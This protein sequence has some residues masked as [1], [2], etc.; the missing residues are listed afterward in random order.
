VN[1]QARTRLDTLIGILPQIIIYLDPL[2]QVIRH[3]R[4]LGELLAAGVEDVSGEK[5]LDHLHPWSE[6][7]ARELQR[8][9]SLPLADG[10]ELRVE[11]AISLK[12]SWSSRGIFRAELQYAGEEGEYLLMLE[13]V[14]SL[15]Q[16]EEEYRRVQ[17]IQSLLPLIRGFGADF[18]DRLTVIFGNLDFALE[19]L[20]LRGER[21]EDRIGEIRDSLSSVI[22][23]LERSNGRLDHILWMTDGGRKTMGE[24]SLA[25][26]VKEVGE[27]A[28]LGSNKTLEVIVANELPPYRGDYEKILQM[29]QNLLVNAVQAGPEAYQISISLELVNRKG[30][31][32]VLISI[33]DH[34]EGMAVDVLARA[35]QPF[36]T[37]RENADG[38]GLF[39]AKNIALEHNG[40]IELE[41]TPGKGSKVHIYLPLNSGESLTGGE[42]R[43]PEGLRVLILDDNPDVRD[44]WERLLY[45]LGIHGSFV[46]SGAK[47]FE[48]FEKAQDSD[49][50]FHMAILED[51][52]SDSPDVFSLVERLSRIRPGLPAVYTTSKAMKLTVDELRDRGFS[53]CLRKPF[54]LVDLQNALI[55]ALYRDQDNS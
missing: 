21:T 3:N 39:I 22:K 46:D 4:N 24:F 33:S 44:I 23:H 30:R 14:T 18:R 27:Q 9:L 28:I 1:A 50:P 52:D 32:S 35:E 53:A 17:R 51:S 45:Q 19:L 6:A 41:S 55:K 13:D 15:R 43:I 36:F 26:T 34:G 47:A 11:Y 38:L 16:M 54:R 20:K 31:E 40:S 8:F 29:F 5:L 37:T 12:T 42:R 2:G 49:Y 10:E 48:R 25:E 7:D